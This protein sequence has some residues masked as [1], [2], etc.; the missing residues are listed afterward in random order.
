MAAC[1]L[2]ILCTTIG[3]IVDQLPEVIASAGPNAV[4]TDIGSTK[5]AIVEAAGADPRFIGGHPMCGSEKTGVDAAR[6]DL[7]HRATW[8]L[9]PTSTTS[10]AAISTLIALINAVGALPLTLDPVGHDT[11]VALDGE[12][13]C[14][15]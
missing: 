12:P 14:R 11:M 5:S 6:V 9:T 13:F 15:T 8:A 4:I 2:V 7:Y 10:E 1:D 3:H